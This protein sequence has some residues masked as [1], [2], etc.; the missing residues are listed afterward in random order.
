GGGGAS[1]IGGCKEL[2]RSMV[3]GDSSME[4]KGGG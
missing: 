2:A 4:Y 1:S 3:Y